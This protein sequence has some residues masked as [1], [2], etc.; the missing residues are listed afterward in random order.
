MAFVLTKLH[1]YPQVLAVNPNLFP[2][3]QRY[4]PDSW[5]KLRNAV[6]LTDGTFVTWP[7]IHKLASHYNVVGEDVRECLEYLMDIG[8]VLWF[9]YITELRDK[10]FT[11]HAT[12]WR[13]S[14]VCFVM[15]LTRASTGK[16][17]ESS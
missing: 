6:K 5:R 12:L 3:A 2:H 8:E 7:Q 1:L 10:V 16:R 9:P 14:D 15:T 11:D 4:I 17:T 13:S